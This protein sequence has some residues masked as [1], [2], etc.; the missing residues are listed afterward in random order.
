MKIYEHYKEIFRRGNNFKVSWYKS[1]LNNKEEHIID[2]LFDLAVNEASFA[3]QIYH[4][5]KAKNLELIP[6]ETIRDY[7]EGGGKGEYPRRDILSKIEKVNL[8]FRSSF[9]N[10]RSERLKNIMLDRELMEIRPSEEDAISLY[11]DYRGDWQ[12]EYSPIR[13][14]IAINL[15]NK[16]PIKPSKNVFIDISEIILRL[17]N[18]NVIR[19]NIFTKSLIELLERGITTYLP[20]FYS[21]L[22]I[23]IPAVS[24]I[25]IRKQTQDKYNTLCRRCGKPLFKKNSK[26]YCTRSENRECYDARYKEERNPGMPTVISRTK[27]H[28]DNCGKYS[29]HNYI[30]KLSDMEMQFCSDKCWET[31][32]KRVYRK[33]ISSTIVSLSQNSTAI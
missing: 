25:G 15:E 10:D 12:K 17:V 8:Y 21:D 29:S 32:R 27:N 14:N 26:H 2:L 4:D 6:S 33:R 22:G 1:L 9:D 28:C 19:E 11:D 3:M 5:Y 24:L 18:D 30:H 7:M 23:K 20:Q 31:Y 16:Y 13:K